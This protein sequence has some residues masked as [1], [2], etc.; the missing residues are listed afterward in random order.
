MHHVGTEFAQAYRCPSTDEADNGRLASIDIYSVVRETRCL[1]E[2]GLT[3]ACAI[4]MLCI[5]RFAS[6]LCLRTTWRVAMSQSRL[7]FVGDS[8]IFSITSMEKHSIRVGVR[9]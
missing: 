6:G 2:S 4:G 3:A 7:N 8:R 1:L 5:A 9:R